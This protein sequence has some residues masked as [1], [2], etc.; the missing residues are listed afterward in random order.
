MSHLRVMTYN[1][2]YF[3]HGTRGLWSTAWAMK[4]IARAIATLDPLPDIVCLQEVESSSV[5]ANLAHP[6][7]T[8]E[9][10]QLS[11]LMGYLHAGLVAEGKPDAYRGYYFPAH[12]YRITK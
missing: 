7:E 11:R 1:V 6:R 5:R 8:P 12:T 2:R 9:D 3:S 4:S 10:T